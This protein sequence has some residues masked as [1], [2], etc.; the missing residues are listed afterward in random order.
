ML[1]Q[2]L[3][4]KDF[5]QKIKINFGKITLCAIL[6][7]GREMDS[8]VWY[9]YSTLSNQRVSWRSGEMVFFLLWHYFNKSG[10][11]SAEWIWF[12]LGSELNECFDEA[13]EDKLSSSMETF[14]SIPPQALEATTE[15]V[16]PTGPLWDR[17]CCCW[18][19]CG[20]EGKTCPSCC[21]KSSVT[22]SFTKPQSPRLLPTSFVTSW[23][24][25]S[26]LSVPWFL[27]DPDPPWFLRDLR[28]LSW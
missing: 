6:K 4:G 14:M 2:D 7:G 25:S 3:S 18:D 10:L 11:W 12:P 21:W 26:W 1:L 24:C 27:S 8:K 17:R 9:S 16:A 23:K 22:T 20:G 19:C 13:M 15:A 5:F 28:L